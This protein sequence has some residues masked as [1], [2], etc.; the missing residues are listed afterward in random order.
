M[1]IKNTIRNIGLA[2]ILAGS[3]IGGSGC[4]MTPADLERFMMNDT[5]LPESERAQVYDKQQRREKQW[6]DI[7]GR[8]G[9]INNQGY[10]I[11]PRGN[12]E[13]S[14]YSYNKGEWKNI[15]GQVNIYEEDSSGNNRI[16][17]KK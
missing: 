12:R 9:Y 3:M 6:I 14:I 15:S 7:D 5:F 10:G 16:Q 13:F 11:V 2:G 4:M 17:L 8:K 1:N